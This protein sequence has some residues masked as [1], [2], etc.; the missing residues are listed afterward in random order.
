[1]WV[2]YRG[3]KHTT[4]REQICYTF[5]KVSFTFTRDNMKSANSEAGSLE[6]S[7]NK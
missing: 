7:K 4:Q 5:I 3:I 2:Y 6:N 1:M